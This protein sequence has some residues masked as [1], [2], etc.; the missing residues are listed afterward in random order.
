MGPAAVRL[1]NSLELA[2]GPSAG[3][4]ST[5]VQPD[6]PVDVHDRSTTSPLMAPAQSKPMSSVGIRVWRLWTTSVA[7]DWFAPVRFVT[8]SWTAGGAVKAL[9]TLDQV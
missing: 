5:A 3:S 9:E 6:Q 8:R 2:L 7:I 4:P 1:R